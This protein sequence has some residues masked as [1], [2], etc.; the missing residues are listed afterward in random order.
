MPMV[1]AYAIAAGVIGFIPLSVFILIP[2]EIAMVYHLSVRNRRPFSL[3]ELGLIWTLLI[4]VGGVLQ[5]VVGSIFVWA[6]PVGW[7]AKSFF[8]FGFV[9]VFGGAVNWYYETENKST[10]RA[11]VTR[12]QPLLLWQGLPDSCRRLINLCR[13]QFVMTGP[14]VRRNV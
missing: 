2:L 4:T 1:F 10:P 8:A 12:R 9:L 7:L 11:E 3:G 5:A 14:P 6:G 13:S